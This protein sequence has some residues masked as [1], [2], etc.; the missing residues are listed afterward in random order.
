MASFQLTTPLTL[1]P[2]SARSRAASSSAVVLMR[3]MPEFS[4]LRERPDR[5]F[6]ECFQL[7]VKVNG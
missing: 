3:H 4:A 1:M 2:E 7:V 5:I 6:K